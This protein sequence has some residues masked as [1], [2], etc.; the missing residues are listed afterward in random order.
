MDVLKEVLGRFNSKFRGELLLIIQVILGSIIN[1]FLIN[2]ILAHH[3]CSKDEKVN[4]TIQYYHSN[5]QIKKQ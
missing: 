2:R 1:H 5:T 4:D 3:Q